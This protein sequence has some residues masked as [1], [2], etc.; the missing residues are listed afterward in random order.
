VRDSR[1]RDIM[2]GGYIPGVGPGSMKSAIAFVV[3]CLCN[4]SFFILMDA[5]QTTANHSSEDIRPTLEPILHKH[6]L[7]AMAAAIVTSD[8]IVGV[9]AVGVRKYGGAQPATLNDEFH[10]GSDTKAMTATILAILVEQ[11]KLTW[12]MTL[13]AALPD[14]AERMDPAYRGVTIEQLLAHRAGFTDASWPAGE[15]FQSM[16]ELGGTPREQRWKYAQEVLSET[17][18]KVQPGTFLYSN[19]SYAIAGVIAERTSNNAWEDMMREWLFK[20]LGMSTCGFGA[21][22]TPGKVDEPW[23][24]TGVGKSHGPVEPGPMSDNPVVIA[25]AGEVHCSVGDWGKFVQAHL[26]GGKGLPGILKPETFKKLHT[27]TYG[28]YG[29]GWLG[30]DRPWGGGQVLTHAGSNTMNYAVAWV[31]PLRDFAVLVMTNQG[32][33]EAAKACDEA[34]GA[35]IM[36]YTSPPGAN[37]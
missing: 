1:V 32:G 37:R 33:D 13:A 23:Q 31:A 25:P 35:L 19:R 2:I 15:T 16:H 10:L 4:L 24:H 28:N 29:F 8:G 9:G 6:D 5:P 27:I 11:G 36:H 18:T 22:G 3:F 26:R 17:P 14:L 21:M 30:V 34:A 20:P 7:P 12:T